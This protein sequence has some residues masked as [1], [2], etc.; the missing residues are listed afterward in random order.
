MIAEHDKYT[1]RMWL[2]WWWPK[3]V[4]IHFHNSHTRMA[5][6]ISNSQKYCKINNLEDFKTAAI[7]VEMSACKLHLSLAE[8]EHGIKINYKV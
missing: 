5:L 3:V 1:F 8:T 2:R 4:G 7:S 6:G